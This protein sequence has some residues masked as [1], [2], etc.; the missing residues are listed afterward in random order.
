MRRSQGRAYELQTDFGRCRAAGHWR[1]GGNPATYVDSAAAR[2]TGIGCALH[3]RKTK[4]AFRSAGSA[5]RQLHPTDHQ[6]KRPVTAATGHAHVARRKSV[7]NS[8]LMPSCVTLP[9]RG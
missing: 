1:D 9:V 2:L 7:M 3:R 8:R 4:V 6:A 5:L